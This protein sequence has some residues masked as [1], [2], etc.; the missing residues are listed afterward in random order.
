MKLLT[1]Q[2]TIAYP[3]RFLLV[4]FLKPKPHL[5]QASLNLGGTTIFGVEFV[6][7]DAGMQTIGLNIEKSGVMRVV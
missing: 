2:L 6:D 4:V 1:V 3:Q 7:Y 5:V